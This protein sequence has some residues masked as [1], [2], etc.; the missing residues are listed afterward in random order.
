MNTN[1]L[2]KSA[3]PLSRD[4]FKRF[5]KK[6]PSH[7]TIIKNTDETFTVCAQP[8]NNESATK[9]LYGRYTGEVRNYKDL[10]K[11]EKRLS[12]DFG[13]KRFAFETSE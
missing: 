12:K 11:L 8:E 10:T 3:E 2:I 7:I 1:A 13:V 6:Q 5:L 4:K 9:I